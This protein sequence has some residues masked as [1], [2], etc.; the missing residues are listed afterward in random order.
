[1]KQDQSSDID[2]ISSMPVYHGS[3]L[4]IE[5]HSDDQNASDLIIRVPN[6]QRVSLPSN[7]NDSKQPARIKR[8]AP[9]CPILYGPTPNLSTT[10]STHNFDNLKLSQTR[11]SNTN[12]LTT[13][14]RSLS[15]AFTHGCKSK[16]SSVISEIT[17]IP[18]ALPD[19][20][21]MTEKL[22]V[23]KSSNKNLKHQNSISMIP[24]LSPPKILFIKRKNLKIRKKQ[25][26]SSISINTQT[27]LENNR[28][29]LT[30]TSTI[31]TTQY[32]EVKKDDLPKMTTFFH[33][34]IEPNDL[35]Q[36]T[37]ILDDD[38]DREQQNETMRLSFDGIINQNISI[39]I[40]KKFHFN[41]RTTIHRNFSTRI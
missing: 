18:S 22:E 20:E 9:I 26:S 30:P 23:P 35:N 41:S 15:R 19:V 38:Y 8:R 17:T 34:F 10:N 5:Q 4:R 2:S 39:K 37:N 33:Q 28:I 12:R 14:L 36:E 13:G 24:K 21:V 11:V 40:L 16:R 32:A 6:F 25:P 3:I 29:N 7:D 1:V 31:I 27:D